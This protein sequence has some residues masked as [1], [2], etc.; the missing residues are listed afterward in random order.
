MVPVPCQD[1]VGWASSS[2]P[3]PMVALGTLMAYLCG[4]EHTANPDIS[5]AID[6]VDVGMGLTITA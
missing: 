1:N 6:S 3:F 2:D 5:A 4:S